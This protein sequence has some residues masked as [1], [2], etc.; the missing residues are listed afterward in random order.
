SAALRARA[1][2]A[3]ASELDPH[4]PYAMVALATL[5]PQMGTWREREAILRS[6]FPGHADNDLLLHELGF[7]LGQV[8][9]YRE[10]AALLDRAARLPP[11]TPTGL[12]AHIIMLWGAERLE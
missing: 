12:Y 4:N 5:K 8:G 6:G 11:P 10:G 3:R 1:A 9:R 7:L 2:V